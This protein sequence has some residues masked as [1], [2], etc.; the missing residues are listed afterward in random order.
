MAETFLE[1]GALPRKA[2]VDAV[3]IAVAVSNGMDFL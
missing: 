1:K 3:H 2:A